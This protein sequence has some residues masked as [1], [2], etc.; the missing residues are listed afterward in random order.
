VPKSARRLLLQTHGFENTPQSDAR[1][2]GGGKVCS[3]DAEGGRIP[4]RSKS[5]RQRRNYRIRTR[6]CFGDEIN[7]REIN[8]KYNNFHLNTD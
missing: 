8:N 4:A 7:K 5:L 6:T 3:A 2:R 1:L